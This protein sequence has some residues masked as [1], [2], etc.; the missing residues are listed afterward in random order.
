MLI[1]L[2]AVLPPPLPPEVVA[3][4]TTSTATSTTNSAATSAATAANANANANAT[5]NAS[6][7]ANGPAD[8][9]AVATATVLP[10][11]PPPALL[12]PPL[13]PQPRHCALHPPTVLRCTHIPA[14]TDLLSKKRCSRFDLISCTRFMARMVA[15]I[16]FRS[17]LTG[18]FL[19]FSKSSVESTVI[20]L[21]RDLRNALV[22]LVLRGL[23]FRLKFLWHFE[24]QKRK[25]C[26]DTGWGGWGGVTEGRESVRKCGWCHIGGEHNARRHL[27]PTRGRRDVTLLSL[28]TNVIPW[29]G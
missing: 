10:P 23:R 16:R 7:T 29:P 3:R 12:P 24:R 21:P 11:P 2:A 26:G 8:A 6:A 15:P 27:S 28:R 19:R 1:A 18:T 9:T 22:H 13:Q 14:K 20:S 25:T 5:A 17:Y 4:D